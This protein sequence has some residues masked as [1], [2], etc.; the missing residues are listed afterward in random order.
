[1]K[2]VVHYWNGQSYT[3]TGCWLSL[4]ELNWGIDSAILTQHSEGYYGD[5]REVGLQD[6]KYIEEIDADKG[7]HRIYYRPS[8]RPNGAKSLSVNVDVMSSKQRTKV[9]Q[10][11][12]KLQKLLEYVD[13]LDGG[14]AYDE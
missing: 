4:L 2:V 8:T 1:M 11:T 7:Y 13:Y 5:V 10:G 14:M 9:N 6:V 12:K 3:Y